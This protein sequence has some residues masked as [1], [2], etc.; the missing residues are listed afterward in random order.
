M[1]I[2][3]SRA[4]AGIATVA[5]VAGASTLAAPATA[6][7]APGAQPPVITTSVDGNTVSLNLADP[8]TGLAN[9][10]V[11]CTPALIDV[12]K[13][14]PLLPDLAAGTFPPLDS[15]DP[16]M[17]AWGP[18][19]AGTNAINRNVTWQIP[20]VPNGVYVAIGVCVRPSAITS[21]GI[22]FTPVL[23]GSPI[24]VGSAVLDLGSVVVGTPGAVSAILE[25]LGIDTGS[26]GS[27]GNLGSVGSLGH[28]GSVG[29]VGSVGDHG[30]A[31]SGAG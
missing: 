16:A 26:L 27:L 13:A 4:L 24:Q 2:N 11:T 23:V 1:R 15:I 14:V 10:L 7:A 17:F 6:S 31:H 21:P 30:S 9:A 25:L 3:L 12:A 29:D 22:A 20:D 5:A 28:L 19:F 8:N 18:V